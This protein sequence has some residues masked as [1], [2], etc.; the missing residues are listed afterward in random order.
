MGR[1]VVVTGAASGMGLSISQRLAG[2]GY[3]V[4]LLDR[5]AEVAERAAE[6]IRNDG[7]SAVAV[8]VDVSDRP[9]VD[10]AMSKVRSEFGPVEILVTSAG[11]DEFAKFTEI[12]LD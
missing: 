12:S 4:A 2:T 3:R 10:E 5:D 9:N 11:V 8:P 7:G 1:V 6:Q